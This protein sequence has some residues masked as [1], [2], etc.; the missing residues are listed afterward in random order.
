MIK[1]IASDLDG[2]LLLPDGSLPE[3]TFKLIE[4]LCQKGI[5]FCVAS[6]RQYAGLT[7]LF[8]PVADKILFIAENGAL[9]YY[10]GE[11]IYEDCISPTALPA[12]FSAVRKIDEA[13]P[14][15]CCADYAYAESAFLPFTTECAK[16]YAHF[17]QVEKLEC[18][19]TED[20][21]CKIAVYD[22]HGSERSAKILSS[23][24][25]DYRVIVSGKVWSDI[26]MPGT[27]KGKAFRFIQRYFHF[28]AREC[29]AF[30]DYMNDLEL[31]LSCENGYVTENGFPP[32]KEK[33]G[34]VI[35]SNAEEGVIRKIKEILGE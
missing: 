4:R 35:P 28:S 13:Y 27:D 10:R 5:L 3:G 6:G 30:G 2:T 24:L 25:P 15:L 20:P 16:Y 26:S 29:M 21:V 12:V 22:P 19:P 14:L 23:A 34:R 18:A 32:L 1:L 31:L 11:R 17:R 7:Q 8:A 9:V 33:I